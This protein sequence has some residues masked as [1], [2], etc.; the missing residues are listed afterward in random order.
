M[1]DTQVAFWLVSAGIVEVIAVFIA[2]FVVFPSD[3]DWHTLLK[4]G[5]AL[6]VLGLV[7][8]IVRSIHYLEHGYY[9][10]DVY[11]PM[12]ITKDIGASLLI[13]YFAFVHPKK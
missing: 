5:F 3:N 6:M 13:Y 1:T 9:P 10:I 12:W 7:V 11:F 2:I 8:Q 4:A